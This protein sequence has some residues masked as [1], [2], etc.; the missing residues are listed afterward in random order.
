MM[1]AA[2]Y[3]D[4]LPAIGMDQFDDLGAVHIALL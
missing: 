2:R 3:P 4:E 1:V